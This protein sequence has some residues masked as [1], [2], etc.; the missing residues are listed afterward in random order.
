VDWGALAFAR[1]AGE[2][3]G[4]VG[5]E[6]ASQCRQAGRI[7]VAE[8]ASVEGRESEDGGV[9]EAVSEKFCPLGICT[10]QECGGDDQSG[11]GCRRV[12]VGDRADV[13]YR[14]GFARLFQQA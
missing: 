4:R 8:D 11:R 10:G 3:L 9:G 13:A 5:E 12:V 14:P 6:R 7:V 1:G 2:W